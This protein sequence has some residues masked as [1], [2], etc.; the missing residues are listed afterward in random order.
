MAVLPQAETKE[1]LLPLASA[2]G[3]AVDFNVCF[4]Q[5]KH[6]AYDPLVSE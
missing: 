3:R 4:V 2:W 1:N 5:Y 6:V